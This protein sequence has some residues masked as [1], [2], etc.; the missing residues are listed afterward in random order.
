LFFILVGLGVYL[1]VAVHSTPAD[2]TPAP[3]IA[4]YVAIGCG[5]A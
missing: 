5:I 3:A 4:R 2:E 1:A